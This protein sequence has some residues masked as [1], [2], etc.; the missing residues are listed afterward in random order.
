MSDAT[1]LGTALIDDPYLLFDH[2]P[3]SLW[4]QDFSGIRRLFDQVRAQ[5]VHE[6]GAYLETQPGFVATCMQ[7]IAVRDVNLETVRMFGAESKEHLL[8]NLDRILRDGMAHHFQAELTALWDSATNWSGEGINYALDGSALDILLHWRILPGHEASWDRVLVTIE[9]ITERKRAERRLANLFEASPISLWEEDYGALKAY[10]DDLRAQGVDDLRAH[11]DAHPEAVEACMGLMRVLDVNQKT[12][13]LFG[14]ESKAQLLA[15]LPRIFRDDMRTHFEQ[16]LLDLWQGRLAYAREGINYDLHGAPLNVQ[17]DLRVMP[18]HEE[19]FAWVLVAIQDITARKKAEEYLYYLGT[20]DVMTGLY[21]RTYFQETMQRMQ[22]ERHDLI[23]FIV[24]DLNELKEVNDTLGHAAGDSLIRRAAEVLKATFEPDAIVARVG[25]DEFV[26]VLTHTPASAAEQALVR[27]R[28]L[29]A[30][31]NK[32]YRGAPLSFA[33]GMATSQ[34]G[35]ALDA[36]L[37]RAD[38]AMYRDKAASTRR[39]RTRSH[40]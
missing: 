38:D 17:V 24:A 37:R 33:L 32:Y 2:A 1:H 19:D 40:P 20:H 11:L 3:I 4:V 28:S 12:L 8:A 15:N 10:F 34:P 18:G 22:A 9:N 36:V 13:D 16:E 25:G 7:Q 29:L 39:S 6:L 21:N 5:G 30:L 31:N 23:T 26:V 27:I 14:A 35:Q